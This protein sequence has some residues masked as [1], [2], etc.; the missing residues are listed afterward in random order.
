MD[1]SICNDYLCGPYQGP[2]AQY[3]R[4]DLSSKFHLFEAAQP[5]ACSAPFARFVGRIPLLIHHFKPWRVGS[6]LVEEIVTTAVKMAG[7][8]WS[9]CELDFDRLPNR[10]LRNNELT[11]QSLLDAFACCRDIEFSVPFLATY[12]SL[13]L[14]KASDCASL[15][16]NLARKATVTN[17]R[18]ERKLAEIK[19]SV[20][21]SKM[22]PS[23]ESLV[24][25]SVI[26]EVIS[27][28]ASVVR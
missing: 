27:G 2:R 11:F 15:M 10:L 23:V 16:R 1:R 26:G 3:V 19:Y 20:P 17:M 6:A 18:L 4:Q 12:P 25:G 24:Y 8:I 14:M 9:R 28:E 22:L 21:Y 13:P 5:R 7:V